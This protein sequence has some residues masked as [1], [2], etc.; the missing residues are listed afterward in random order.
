MEGCPHYACGSG[1][2]VPGGRYDR[3]RGA[4]RPSRVVEDMKQ[5]RS[6]T[7]IAAPGPVAGPLSACAVSGCRRRCPPRGG[8]AR[9]DQ[10]RTGTALMAKHPRRM[11]HRPAERNPRARAARRRAHGTAYSAAELTA[12]PATSAAWR[13]SSQ[14]S[15]GPTICGDPRRHR[16]PVVA[17]LDGQSEPSGQDVIERQRQ[18]LLDRPGDLHLQVVGVRVEPA[19]EAPLRT[20][21][22]DGV[23]LCAVSCVEGGQQR[24]VEVRR[25]TARRGATR[26]PADLARAAPF[27]LE[28]APTSARS[29][30]ADGRPLARDC[31]APRPRRPPRSCRYVVYLPPRTVTRPGHAARR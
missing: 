15:A 18:L 29:A 21:G 27:T 19:Q 11:G 25:W 8:A 17:G 31:Q 7:W 30:V 1:V 26:R 12:Y 10:G 28:G 14:P 9:T 5:P 4:R 20:Q 3:S 6:S 22:H 24:R 2:A 16:R 13:A 23:G